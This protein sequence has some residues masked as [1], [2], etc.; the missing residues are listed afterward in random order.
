MRQRIVCLHTQLCSYPVIQLCSHRTGDTHGR[1]THRRG[2]WLILTEDDV[3]VSLVFLS[4]VTADETIDGHS[5]LLFLFLGF[6]LS[7]VQS[8]RFSDV[9]VFCFILGFFNTIS[10]R[11][12]CHPMSSSTDACLI[13]AGPPPEG[14]QSNFNNPTSL[15]P[16][17]IAVMTIMVVWGAIFT[18]CRFYVNLRKLRLSDCEFWSLNG[19]IFG[20]LEY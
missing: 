15:G 8:S 18:I 20:F 11:R 2:H 5:R 4:G 17:V 12:P 10:L 13:P 1:P 16:T 9:P 6:S 7:T 19:K 14:K 3:A